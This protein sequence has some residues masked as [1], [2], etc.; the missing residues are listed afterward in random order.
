MSNM[1][2]LVGDVK[3]DVNSVV[4]SE[5]NSKQLNLKGNTMNTTQYTQDQLEALLVS[6]LEARQIEA[7]LQCSNEAIARGQALVADAIA[8]GRANDVAVGKR[9]VAEAFVQ[10]KESLVNELTAPKYTSVFHKKLANV[11]VEVLTVIG[12]RQMLADVGEINLDGGYVNL[13]ST[14]IQ[15]GKAIETEVL[16]A[17]IEAV[18]SKAVKSVVKNLGTE[19]NV[20]TIRSA[21]EAAA[22]KVNLEFEAWDSNAHVGTAKLVLNALVT[23]SELFTMGETPSGSGKH[24]KCILPTELLQAN[25]AEAVEAAHAVARFPAMVCKPKKWTSQ[26][27]GG[28]LTQELSQLAPLMTMRK[29]PQN[30]RKWVLNGLQSSASAKVRA[31][32]NKAQEIGYR[33]NKKVL[34]AVQDIADKSS[35]TNTVLGLHGVAQ[36]KTSY[37][38]LFPFPFGKDWD[39]KT[40]KKK[41]LAVV[42]A[43]TE[44]K[45]VYETTRK[46][47]NSQAIGLNN[48]IVE[49]AKY[50]DEAA[51]YFPAFIDWRGRVYARGIINIQGH[52]TV[53]GCLEFAEGK[54]LGERGLFWLKAHVAASAGYDKHSFELRAKWTEDNWDMLVAYAA[55]PSNETCPSADT[56]FTLLAA[57]YALQEALELSNPEEYI[58]HIPVA[59]DATCS[60]LQHFSAMFHDEVGGAM[61]NLTNNGKDQ[62]SD[63][64]A[65]VSTTANKYIAS[66]CTDAAMKKVL[67]GYVISRSMAKAPV[68]T[69]PYSATLHSN[70]G[71]VT[72]DILKEGTLPLDKFSAQELA[73][74]I[75]KALRKACEEIVPAAVNAMSYLQALCKSSDKALRW[76]TPVG[77]PVVNYANESVEEFVELK[78]FNN[79]ARLRLKVETTTEAYDKAGATS[80]IAPNLV[81]SM[82]SAHL[83]ATILK[84]LS[85]DMLCI[86]DSFATHAVDVDALHTALRT[87]FVEDIYTEGHDIVN[88]LVTATNTFENECK[89]AYPTHGKLNLSAV[90]SSPYMFC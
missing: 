28:Y 57:V 69:L 40:A 81:H 7:E 79:E 35:M 17:E 8:N 21:Y 65:A 26:F 67:K 37:S 3:V 83:C 10:A 24:Y 15:V 25:L 72:K 39:R 47:K 9:L 38:T 89:V 64:Y 29:L 23:N 51:I 71:T 58:C 2:N 4:N 33:V 80:G 59:M 13:Q 52:D 56:A 5:V 84:D 53:K 6:P 88:T 66:F 87:S 68:M 32:M 18:N 61:T 49:L 34:A 44:A 41:E 27:Q 63:I 16:I 22:E 85:I 82:D 43:W 75:A 73:V 50:Q 14:L 31:A 60:G 30:E 19:K 36:D 20:R 74:P 46:T 11:N 54:A 45:Q 42:D 55:S 12:L 77:V 1:L 48:R 86:H 70:M 90:L 62:K 78:G 76:V